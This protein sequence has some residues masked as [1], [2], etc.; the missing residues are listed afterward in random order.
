MSMVKR[1]ATK[2]GECINERKFL[3]YVSY[4]AKYASDSISSFI[5]KQKFAKEKLPRKE[6]R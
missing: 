6:L 2:N 3:K 1:F 5:T 4:F